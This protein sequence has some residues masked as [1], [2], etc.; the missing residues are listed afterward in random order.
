M[1]FFK[2]DFRV[3]VDFFFFKKR[4]AANLAKDSNLKVFLK[5]ELPFLRA[6]WP[7]V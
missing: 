4:K 6:E 1:N 3:K 7:I 2:K 5:E